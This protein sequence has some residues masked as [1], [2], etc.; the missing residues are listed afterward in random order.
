MQGQHLSELNLELE[1]KDENW[2]SKAKPMISALT[3]N[4]DGLETYALSEDGHILTPNSYNDDGNLA[5]YYHF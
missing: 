3:D 1:F 4:N 2:S 5:V